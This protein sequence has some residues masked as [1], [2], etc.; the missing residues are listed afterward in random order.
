MHDSMKLGVVGA[1]QH[2]QVFPTF[3]LDDALQHA[4]G[5]P[6]AEEIG[7]CSAAR[8]KLAG[9]VQYEVG[10]RSVLPR[11]PHVADIASPGEDN[12]I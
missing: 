1:A 2:D 12:L 7:G 3:L 5:T 10:F 8:P 11:R 9:V 4:L 6:A